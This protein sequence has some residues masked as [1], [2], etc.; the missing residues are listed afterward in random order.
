MKAIQ[1]F[2]STILATLILIS[3]C[4]KDDDTNSSTPNTPNNSIKSPFVA[5]VDNES[6]P[7]AD[8]EF[9][10]AKYVS[11]TKMLQ[12]IGQPTDQKETIVITLMAFGGKVATATDWKAGT[13]DF[14]PT[15][16]TTSGYMASAEY[17]KWNGSGYDQW[18]TN[19]ELAKTGT[20][21]IES[22]D[23]AKIK[24]TFSFDVVKKNSDGSFNSSNIK[25][26]TGGAFELTINNY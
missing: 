2:K 20:L 11:S 21:I 23:G 22:N 14:N 1:F 7:V 15:Q 17:N 8:I 9:T 18:F 24:G 6:F 12:I 3:S 26:I 25:K 16:L 5:K 4:S 10:K 13:Y 19:W